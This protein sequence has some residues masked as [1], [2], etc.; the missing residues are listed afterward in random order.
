[1]DELLGIKIRLYNVKSRF[2]QVMGDFLEAKDTRSS[3]L[4]CLP[5][6][7]NNGSRSNPSGSTEV[8]YAS[9]DTH[10]A[11]LGLSRLMRE[12]DDVDDVICIQY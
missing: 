6:K 10:A 12:L 3:L 9:G 7:W 11:R 4:S 2:K 8:N 5:A 1:M